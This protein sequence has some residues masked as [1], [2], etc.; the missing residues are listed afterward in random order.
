M[1]QSLSRLSAGC[2]CVTDQPG[3]GSFPPDLPMETVPK[4]PVGV[5]P[6]LFS[7]P[8]GWAAVLDIYR[9]QDSLWNKSYV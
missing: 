6:F 9:I 4:P 1:G 8:D 3:D 5:L 2:S 7:L